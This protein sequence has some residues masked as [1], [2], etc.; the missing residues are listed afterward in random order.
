M[1]ASRDYEWA[2]LWRSN[3]RLDGKRE[4]LL[5]EDCVPVLFATK[6][7]AKEWI[8]KQYSYIRNRPDLR[9]EPHGWRMPIAIKVQVV[10]QRKG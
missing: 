8:D 5:R 2:V 10:L 1:R 6:A 4:W 3:N 7:A 9:A